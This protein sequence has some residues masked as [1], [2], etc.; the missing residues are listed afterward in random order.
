[1][2][3]MVDHLDLNP[4]RYATRQ[5]LTMDI[6]LRSLVRGTQTLLGASPVDTRTV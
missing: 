6:S 2:V 1:M 5:L 3:F 4:F